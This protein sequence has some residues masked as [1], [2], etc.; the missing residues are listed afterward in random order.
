M[1]LQQIQQQQS[2]FLANLIE[3]E[4]DPKYKYHY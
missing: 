2:L 4:K 1:K 3:C